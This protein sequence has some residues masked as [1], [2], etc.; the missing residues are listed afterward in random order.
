MITDK[1]TGRSFIQDSPNK[2]SGPYSTS[3]ALF[4]FRPE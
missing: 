3:E 4:V 2:M 1:T